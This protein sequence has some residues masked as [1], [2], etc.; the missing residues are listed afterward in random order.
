[1]HL[2]FF[3]RAAFASV[4]VV[5]G[6]DCLDTEQVELEL[7]DVLDD[8]V[9]DEFLTRVTVVRGASWWLKLAVSQRE[10][11]L[12]SR[13]LAVDPADCPFLAEVVARSVERGVA[14]LPEWRFERLQLHVP[15]ELGVQLFGTLDPS[16]GKRYGLG[17]AAW[18][19]LTPEFGW[20]SVL[21]V[22]NATPVALFG[23]QVQFAGASL[24]TGL[25]GIVHLGPHELRGVGRLGYGADYG[26]GTGFDE[27]NR[28]WWIGRPTA[29]ADIGLAPPGPL[30]FWFRADLLLDPVPQVVNEEQ[31]P[32]PE[33]VPLVRPEESVRLGLVLEL[34]G[35]VRRH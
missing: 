32:G 30:R 25:G 18:I 8:A 3:L 17:G 22:H 19:G 13:Q 7:R 2:L 9:V 14:T 20:Q 27:N 29:Q 26:R 21:E 5:D 11:V 6:A 12:W 31:S 35:S 28:E 10:N 16:G 1:V 4:E 23:G 24:S 33:L 15:A 34:A